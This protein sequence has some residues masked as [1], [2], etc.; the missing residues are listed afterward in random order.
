MREVGRVVDEGA[1]MDA[2]ALR[3]MLKRFRRT[4][5]V[6]LVRRIWNPV[7]EIEG[8]RFRHGKFRARMGP[9]A[10]ATGKGS[11]RHIATKRANFGLF[12]LTFGGVFARTN[13]TW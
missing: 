5:L 12:G 7:R 11:K 9:S 1:E 4:N 6:A 8:V 3:Q 2:K 10:L 13:P